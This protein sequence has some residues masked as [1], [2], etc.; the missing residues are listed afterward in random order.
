MSN[1]EFTNLNIFDSYLSEIVV[2]YKNPVKYSEMQTVKC[3]EDAALILRSVW[4]DQADHLEVFMMICLSRS[5]RVL[6]WS[7]ISTG[8]LTGC[9][10]DP[11]IIFQTALKANAVGII[12]AHNHPSGNKQ[13]SE[14]DRNL[15][16]KLKSA[17]KVLD[18]PVLDHLI[19]TS[20]EYF[21]FADEGLL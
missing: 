11:K 20:E 21:S 3:S 4:S 9:V 8:G 1:S 10:V 5:N 17:G 12:L 18:I 2:N 14:S 15:T 7:R 6:G 19:L 16:R 13:P